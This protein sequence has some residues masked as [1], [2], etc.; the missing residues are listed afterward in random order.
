MMHI[1]NILWDIKADLCWGW[2]GVTLVVL[3]EGSGK[4]ITSPPT[5]ASNFSPSYN[6]PN[7]LYGIIEEKKML[8]EKGGERWGLGGGYVP[9]NLWCFFHSFVPPL[10]PGPRVR[11]NLLEVACI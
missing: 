3:G 8:E 9:V 7:F 1:K 2:E 5:P 11:Y 10:H 4:K 6:Q